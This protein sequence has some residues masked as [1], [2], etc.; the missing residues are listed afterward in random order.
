MNTWFYLDTPQLLPKTVKR[1]AFTP[2]SVCGKC[3]PYTSDE[4]LFSAYKETAPGIIIVRCPD[5]D[6]ESN[7]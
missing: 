4:W 6:S 7:R 5:C 2:C 1:Y 3:E